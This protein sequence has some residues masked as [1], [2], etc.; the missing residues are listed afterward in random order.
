MTLTTRSVPPAAGCWPA[1][2]RAGGDPDLA[3]V[4]GQGYRAGAY[5]DHRR[6]V[7]AV[8]ADPGQRRGQPVSRPHG[9]PGDRQRV[10]AVP[11]RDGG[12]D[13][14]GARIHAGDGAVEPVGDPDRS[15]AEGDGR[16]PGADGDLLAR[17]AAARGCATATPGTV[18]PFPPS[19]VEHALW[20]AV[21]VPLHSVYVAFQRD[22]ALI[23]VDTD[24]CNGTDLAGCG[25]LHPPAAR[26]G[27]QPE[28]VVLD[29]Q[30]QTSTPPIR[31]ITTFRSSTPRAATPR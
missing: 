5:R 22:D 4:G 17:L 26:T 14:V 7:P 13:G 18:K 8:G 29:Q 24:A 19:N 2:R 31:L 30:T 25:N 23:V 9:P 10:R 6:G 16:R 1:G 15:E 21:D 28:S 11:G 27:A 3:A 12:G 20:L